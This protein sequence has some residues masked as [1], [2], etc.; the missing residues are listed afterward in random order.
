MW[1]ILISAYLLS[2]PLPYLCLRLLGIQL[3]YEHVAFWLVALYSFPL[4]L[5]GEPLGEPMAWFTLAIYW[6]LALAIV[7]TWK[8][9]RRRAQARRASL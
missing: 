9:L 3:P 1:R 7:V 8:A 5:V 6:T 2:V 4:W